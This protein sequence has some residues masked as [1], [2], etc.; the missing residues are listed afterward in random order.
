MDSLVGH[1]LDRPGLGARGES[2]RRRFQCH[3][4][5][6]PQRCELQ[7]SC[8]FAADDRPLAGTALWTGNGDRFDADPGF[9]VQ[10]ATWELGN[11]IGGWS[12][13]AT[14]IEGPGLGESDIIILTGTDGYEG[15][16]A[17]LIVDWG[18]GGGRFRGAVFPGQKP[19]LP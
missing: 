16:T 14:G 9:E 11:E 10:A 1:P 18:C 19:P 8:R 7:Y 17:Y 5:R 12:G 15:P 13:E 6:F 2:R 4:R 3:R